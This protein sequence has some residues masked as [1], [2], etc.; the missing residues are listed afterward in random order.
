MLLFPGAWQCTWLIMLMTRVSLKTLKNDEWE[1]FGA[2]EVF[3]SCKLS[4]CI[5]FINS[6]KIRRH[7]GSY[8][9]VFNINKDPEF[10][11]VHKFLNETW[12]LKTQPTDKNIIWVTIKGNAM[13]V[14][15]NCHN[16]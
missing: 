12:I 10:R 3:S 2:E 16:I 5:K 9:N 15:H 6:Y 8:Y 11:L 4:F 13:Y 14:K 1:G 7:C